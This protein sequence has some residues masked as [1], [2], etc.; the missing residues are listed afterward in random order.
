MRSPTPLTAWSYADFPI[1][2]RPHVQYRMQKF[3]LLRAGVIERGLLPRENVHVAPEID[4]AVLELAHTP[5]YIAAIRDGTLTTA[6]VREMGFDWSPGLY[7]RGCRIVGSALAAGG[8]ALRCGA[9]IVLG[10]GA[11]H[12]FADRGRGFCI[13]NDIVITARALRATGR[14][15]RVAVLDCDVHQGD[16]TAALTAEDPGIY[17]FSVHAEKNYPFR[18]EVSDLDIALPDNAGD[19]EY[20]DAVDAGLAAILD[21]PEI[22]LVI[23]IAG[24]D[25]FVEDRLGRLAV[26]AEGLRS[27]D[28]LVFSTCRTHGIPVLI[29]LGGGYCEPIDQ[30][31]ALGLQTVA[32]AVSI[33][34]SSA[35][36]VGLDAL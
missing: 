3:P 6:A 10:G 23:Y 24:A 15:R 4:P 22:D 13:F 17:T 11:H 19:R 28:D 14:V 35:Q 26:S 34:G 27:R 12:S 1:V 7:V 30:T 2:L 29:L 31:V 8:A 9:G 18:K 33:F 16:G 21:E 25:P 20:L 5:G 32:V 36:H